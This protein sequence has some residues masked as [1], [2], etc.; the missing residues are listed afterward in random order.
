M[1]PHA[2]VLTAGHSA[3]GCSPLLSGI[4]LNSIPANPFKKWENWEDGI[5]LAFWGIF[6]IVEN[7]ILARSGWKH[8]FLHLQMHTSDGIF[9]GWFLA[10][11]LKPY[12]PSTLHIF[13]VP[14]PRHE[15]ALVH[16]LVMWH[17]N[18]HVAG[19]FLVHMAY[20]LL[21]TEMMVSV[22]SLNGALEAGFSWAQI[23]AISQFC[24]KRQ[25]AVNVGKESSVH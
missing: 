16:T 7:F 25:K 1:T 6:L 4:L 23:H 21:Y 3:S 5:R 8:N 2:A 9:L 22:K 13:L 10:L 24:Q 11:F 19:T 18:N 14:G 15:A 12:F 17:N 20:H